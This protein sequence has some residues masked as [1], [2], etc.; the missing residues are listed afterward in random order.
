MNNLQHSILMTTLN[1]SLGL[2]KMN[3]LENKSSLLAI[4]NKNKH[5]FLTENLMVCLSAFIS[6]ATVEEL[7][8]E[9]LTAELCFVTMNM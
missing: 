8:R 5:D 6:H 9:E 3:H 2:R 7:W 4:A 1:R